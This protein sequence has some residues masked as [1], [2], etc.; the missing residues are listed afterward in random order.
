MLAV[1]CIETMGFSSVYGIERLILDHFISVGI[2]VQWEP[3]AM[4]SNTS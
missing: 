1:L 2:S 4:A 3:G